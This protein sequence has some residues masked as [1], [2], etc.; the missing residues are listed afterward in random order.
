MMRSVIACA[1]A[2][3]VSGCALS[4]TIQPDDGRSFQVT[5]RS[6]SEVW[7]A[8]ILTVGSVGEISAMNRSIGEIR[9]FRGAG[10]WTSGN[11]LGVFISPPSDKARDFAVSVVGIKTARGQITGSDYTDT[12]IAMMKARLEETK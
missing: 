3:V 9:G 8:G 1:L 4:N 6:Y 7:N 10:A 12:M 2:A 11:A 5:D